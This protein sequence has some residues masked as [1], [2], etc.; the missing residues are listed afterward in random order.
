MKKYLT[1]KNKIKGF[2]DVKETVK[3]VEK[4]AASYIHVLKKQVAILSEYREALEKMLSR[5]LNFT[6]QE[7]HPLLQMGEGGQKA[8][9]I[10]AGDKGMVGGLYH[11]LINKY[12]EDR[13]QY[14]NIWVIG[15]VAREYLEEEGIKEEKISS[16]NVDFSQPEEINKL[17]NKFIAR[18]Q[19]NNWQNIDIAY[20]SFVS[21][22]EQKPA[23]INFLPFSMA[24][25]Q[26][27]KEKTENNQGLPIFEPSK[28]HIFE[29]LL[30]KYINVFF[31]HI[32]LESKLAEFSARTVTSEH[33]VAKTNNIIKKFNLIFLKERKKTITQKQ[34]ESLIGHKKDE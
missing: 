11:D 14:K 31:T 2:K 10:I 16:Y 20:S 26:N 27:N 32:F 29:V 5:I 22:A 21:L 7:N 18:F 28:N 23:F 12:L 30:K 9:I 13:N 33:A 34:L 19:E 4:I 6:N 17:S 1:Y 24:T 15:K 8:L 25:F 3:M